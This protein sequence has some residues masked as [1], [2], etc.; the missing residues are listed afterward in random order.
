MMDQRVL[1]AMGELTAALNAH[2]GV[3]VAQNALLM[4]QNVHLKAL[5][6]ALAGP[7]PAT[8]EKLVTV[9][10]VF[11]DNVQSFWLAVQAQAQ[12]NQR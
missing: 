2:R 7:S 10:A 8:V 11:G 9:I 6:D 5:S 4:T 3:M 12:Q 1:Q